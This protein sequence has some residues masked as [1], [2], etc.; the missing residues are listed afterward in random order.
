M[1][2]NI[3]YVLSICLN[4]N[5]WVLIGTTLFLGF[6]ALFVPYFSEVIKRYYFAPS[7]IIE[8]NEIS[9][10]CHKTKCKT[11]DTQTGKL[12]YDEPFYQFRFR[13]KNKGKSQAKKC[14]VVM[15][16]LFFSDS[17]GNF[18]PYTPY[19]PVNLN[20]GSGY[21][22]F[23]DINPHRTF[24]CDLLS[25][26]S[27]EQQERLVKVEKYINPPDTPSYEYGIILN[28]KNIFFSQPN[29]LPKGKYKVEIAVFS[30]NCK[31]IKTTFEISWSGNWKD[32]EQNMFREIVIEQ[33]QEGE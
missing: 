8:F 26:P 3:N 18:R 10:D 4:T 20:W 21:E 12:L 15:Q 29:R 6:V 5:E 32:D 7:L 25:V 16:K 22:E 30:E 31:S 13:V 19:T 27:K 33:I 24:F 23:V 1:L 28:A 11:W 2:G 14:E 17:A 9:P